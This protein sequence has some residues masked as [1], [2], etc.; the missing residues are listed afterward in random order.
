M[1][2]EFVPGRREPEVPSNTFAYFFREAVRRIWVSKRTSFV[3]VAMIAISLLILGSFLLVAENLSRAVEQWQGRSRV[4]VYLD[5]H[6]TPEQVR[7]VDA[8]LGTQAALA[9]RRVVTREEALARFRTHFANLSEVVGQLDENPFP[10]SYEI[11]V[12]PEVAASPAFAVTIAHI[13]ALPGVDQVQSDFQWIERLRRLV[14][15][16]NIAGLATG[17]ILALA[18]AFTIAN[19][20]RLTMML[21]REEIEIM[22][23]VGATERIIR[24]PFLIEGFLQGTIG[25]L[26]SI[27]LLWGTFEL[28][29]R[30]LASSSSIIWSFLFAGFLPWQ[31]LAALVAGGMLA[32]WFGSWLS[33]RERIAEE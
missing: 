7:G 15:V 22:R 31:K 1:P 13:R 21:Y 3:A 26:L 33:V 10:A 12:Q 27:V 20:I 16:I 5:P 29:R 11:E 2:R 25:G 30:S 28:A 4:V 6:A 24:G 23:L 17:G 18:A 8:F 19:V 14:S 32:G 9:R